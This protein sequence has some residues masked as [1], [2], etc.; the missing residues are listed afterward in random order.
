MRVACVTRNS[1][2]PTRYAYATRRQPSPNDLLAAARWL[3]TR[4]RI[5]R[6]IVMGSL[7]LCYSFLRFHA[8]FSRGSCVSSST[9]S[10]SL[11]LLAIFLPPSRYRAFPFSLLDFSTRSLFPRRYFIVPFAST[12]LLLLLLFSLLQFPC[13]VHLQAAL[14]RFHAG[15]HA[16]A[17]QRTRIGNAWEALKRREAAVISRIH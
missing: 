14:G 10:A 12:L 9:A 4:D 16:D 2:Q 17:E 1:S 11:P 8:P 13:C 7:P 15:K 6:R 3:T 5:T